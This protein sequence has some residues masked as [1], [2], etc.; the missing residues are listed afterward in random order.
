MV[1]GQNKNDLEESVSTIVKGQRNIKSLVESNKESVHSIEKVDVKSN[2]SKTEIIDKAEFQKD[3]TG[4]E[5]G[6]E[7]EDDGNDDGNQEQE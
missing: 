7:R 3:L 4:D 1:G 6:D 5:R 2:V